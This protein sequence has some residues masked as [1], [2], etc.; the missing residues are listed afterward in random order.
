MP[1]PGPGGPQP[2]SQPSPQPDT[3]P[4]PHDPGTPPPPDTESGPAD[5]GS[6]APSDTPPQ[7]TQHP[8]R[9]PDLP[10]LDAHPHRLVPRPGA[11]PAPSLVQVLATCPD[12]FLLL[13]ARMN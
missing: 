3:G 8:K 10:A 2:D 6:P 9:R 4:A 5:A 13:T 1:V 12:D 11:H 7:A